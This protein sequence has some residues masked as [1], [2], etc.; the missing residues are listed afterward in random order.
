MNDDRV[1]EGKKDDLLLLLG[2][3]VS[4]EIIKDV[5]DISDS[6]L[7]LYVKKLQSLGHQVSAIS[8]NEARPKLLSTYACIKMHHRIFKDR[9]LTGRLEKSLFEV[10]EIEKIKLILDT[11][12][13]VLEK[14]QAW[15]FADEVPEGYRQLIAAAGVG[16]SRFHLSVENYWADYLR[17][18]ARDK[19]MAPSKDEF[20]FKKREHFVYRL[21]DEMI[22]LAQGYIGAKFDHRLCVMINNA[23]LEL[24][25]RERLI[26]TEIFGLKGDKKSLV[27]IGNELDLTK[28]RTE[29]ISGKALR[30]LRY[31]LGVIIEKNSWNISNA[32]AEKEAL[33]ELHQI[34]TAKLEKEL[35]RKLTEL[36]KVYRLKLKVATGSDDVGVVVEALAV[37]NRRELVINFVDSDLSIMALNN[38]RGAGCHYMWQLIQYNTNDLLKFRNMG[39]K[40]I[41]ELKEL[42]ENYGLKFGTKFSEIEI[43]YLEAETTDKRK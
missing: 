15:H 21:L 6:T 39:K 5:L 23:L 34:E 11:G 37:F 9:N 36:D 40:S 38:L 24:S 26:T 7:R 43:A 4:R 30:R 28:M 17:D 33:A 25:E 3:P 22:E 35:Q 8:L 18:L 13:V 32:W 41:A 2:I 31:R 42:V 14:N 20:T 29:Q 12:G 1:F 10:L 19:R 16:A 27:E